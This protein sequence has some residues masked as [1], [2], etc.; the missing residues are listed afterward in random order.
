MWLRSV[1]LAAPAFDVVM[2]SI[3]RVTPIVSRAVDQAVAATTEFGTTLYARV[4]ELYTQH[5]E[6]IGTPNPG[7]RNRCACI[8]ANTVFTWCVLN[9]LELMWRLRSPLL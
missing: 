5:A 9:Q 2:K 6:P 1:G 3:D 7:L 4:V 8:V